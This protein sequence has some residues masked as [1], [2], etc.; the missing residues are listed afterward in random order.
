MFDF[1]D[2]NLDRWHRSFWVQEKK[3][4]TETTSKWG[5]MVCMQRHSSAEGHLALKTVHPAFT[6][7]PASPSAASSIFLLICRQFLCL[8]P[9]S[10]MMVF[11]FFSSRISIVVPFRRLPSDVIVYLT[12][13]VLSTACAQ[14][15]Y[16]CFFLTGKDW[17]GTRRSCTPKVT[18][19]LFISVTTY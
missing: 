1:Y 14:W 3:N 15:F 18:L 6:N 9:W 17:D 4:C 13:S 8:S 19:M 12:F 16:M 10:S 5:K 11:F 2:S 7:Q